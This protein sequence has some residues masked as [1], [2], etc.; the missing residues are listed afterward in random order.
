MN[1]QTERSL[2]GN[3]AQDGPGHS[4]WKFRSDGTGFMEQGVTKSTARFT[5]KLNGD[6]LELS[7][8]GACVLYTVER[9]D[10]VVLVLRNTYT[11]AVYRFQRSDGK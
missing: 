11:S 9:N 7:T 8:S 5:W 10:G 4:V 6:S 2:V 1:A 3:W